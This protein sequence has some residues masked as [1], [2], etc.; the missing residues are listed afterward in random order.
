[1]AL[2][3]P[4]KNVLT[5]IWMVNEDVIFTICNELGGVQRWLIT[6]AQ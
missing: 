4:N 6:E 5:L 1:M 2:P 3:G